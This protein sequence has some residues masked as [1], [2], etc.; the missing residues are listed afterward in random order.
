MDW[1]YVKIRLGEHHMGRYEGHERDFYIARDGITIHPLYDN[2]TLDYDIAVIK[3]SR[4]V[5][6]TQRIKPV[7]LNTGI[8][9]T[10][11]C[12]IFKAVAR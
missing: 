5:Q 10:G 1:F 2:R 6:F 7:C 8:N 4:I 11:K 9:F 12:Y 3:L